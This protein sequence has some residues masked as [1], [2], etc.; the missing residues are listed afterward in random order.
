[1]LKISK[2]VKTAEYLNFAD[3]LINIYTYG[4]QLFNN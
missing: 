4:T 1:M 3:A 2:L